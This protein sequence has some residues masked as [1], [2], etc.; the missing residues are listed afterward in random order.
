MVKL[1]AKPN[2]SSFSAFLTSIFFSKS[3]NIKAS[4][5]GFI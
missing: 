2:I 1:F 3:Q 5:S 4:E